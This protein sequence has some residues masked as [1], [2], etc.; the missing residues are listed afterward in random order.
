ME[1][2]CTV[3]YYMTAKKKKKT[4]AITKTIKQLEDDR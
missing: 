2:L 4:E 1:K 3:C